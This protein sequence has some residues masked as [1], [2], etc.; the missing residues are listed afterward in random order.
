MAPASSGEIATSAI[1]QGRM[2]GKEQEFNTEE[3]AQLAIDEHKSNKPLHNPEILLPI[4]EYL[5]HNDK[6]MVRY[7]RG[8]YDNPTIHVHTVDGFHISS[9]K[10]AYECD[11]CGA[12]YQSKGEFGHT[13]F[14]TSDPRCA[15][16]EHSESKIGSRGYRERN[17]TKICVCPD[18]EQRGQID[19][20]IQ[21]IEW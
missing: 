10:C 8:E 13:I 15:K 5:I 14:Q 21:H 4:I 17:L 16:E 2:D 6:Q 18:L 9:D 7:R 20:H 11:K 1:I 19:D 3:L 12:I